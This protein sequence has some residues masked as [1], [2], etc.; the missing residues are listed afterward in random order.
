M[1]F[2]NSETGATTCKEC[3]KGKASTLKQIHVT[4]LFPINSEIN[5]S[6]ITHSGTTFGGLATYEQVTLGDRKFLLS[7]TNFMIQ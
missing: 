2:I 3:F 7:R 4:P 5:P 6:E 1:F